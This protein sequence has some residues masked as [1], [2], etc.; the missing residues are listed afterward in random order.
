MCAEF[1]RDWPEA[2]R[3]YEDA[4]HVLREVTNFGYNCSRNCKYFEHIT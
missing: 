4:Y 1:R 3:S 2:L